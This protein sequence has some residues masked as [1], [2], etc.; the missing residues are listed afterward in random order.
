MDIFVIA[1]V[2]KIH[3]RLPKVDDENLTGYCGSFTFI[4]RRA[5]SCDFL[6]IAFK[7]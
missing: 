2:N 1:T 5:F 3:V 7:S 4:F 6:E